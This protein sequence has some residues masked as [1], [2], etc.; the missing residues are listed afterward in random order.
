MNPG[1]GCADIPHPITQFSGKQFF[2]AQRIGAE[3][4]RRGAETQGR[5]LVFGEPTM[6]TGIT[7]CLNGLEE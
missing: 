4:S 1:G 6:R 2:P 3:V 7:R 5:V